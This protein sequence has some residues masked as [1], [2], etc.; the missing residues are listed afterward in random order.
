MWKVIYIFF[1]INIFS[2]GFIRQECFYLFLLINS[3][4][5]ISDRSFGGYVFSD[6]GNSVAYYIR[7]CIHFLSNFV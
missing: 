1:I 2:V 6:V 4:S 3:L 7:H 5:V